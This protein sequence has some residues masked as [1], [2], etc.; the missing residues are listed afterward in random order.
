MSLPALSLSDVPTS[1]EVWD[2][3]WELTSWINGG[4]DIDDDVDFGDPR[5]TGEDSKNLKAHKI[6][7]SPLVGHHH[8]QGGSDYRLLPGC[9]R[10]RNF[11]LNSTRNLWADIDGEGV[12]TEKLTVC[13]FGV[14]VT[15]ATG[16]AAGTV[17]LPRHPGDTF[18]SRSTDLTDTDTYD[19]DVYKWKVW[20]NSQDDPGGSEILGYLLTYDVGGG[21]LPTLIQQ[22]FVHFVAGP[23]DYYVLNLY[24]TSTVGSDTDFPFHGLL[25]YKYIGE[26]V[27]PE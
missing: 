16:S 2:I 26:L 6:L 4:I 9:L 7:W 10:K 18:G 22:W 21:I 3:L 12:P 24:L 15:V 5:D 13:S 20:D 17:T 27:D 11:D 14:T 25:F 8:G 19:E 23:P 1:S